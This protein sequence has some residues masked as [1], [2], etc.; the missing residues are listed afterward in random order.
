MPHQRVEGRIHHLAYLVI[1]SGNAEMAVG[2]SSDSE[3]F[4][5][6]KSSKWLIQHHGDAILRLAGVTNVAAWRALQAELVQPR[7]L[8]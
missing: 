5:F 2:S 6:D 7:C 3:R 8:P 1:G 4:P